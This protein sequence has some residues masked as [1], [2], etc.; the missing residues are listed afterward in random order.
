M[1]VD[2]DYERVPRGPLVEHI[3]EMARE[4][5]EFDDCTAPP[6]P[7]LGGPVDWR[8]ED[9]EDWTVD[10]DGDAVVLSG[11]TEG[12]YQVQTRSATYN[13]PGAAHPAEYERRTVR[14]AVEVR[15]DWS[16][17]PIGEYAIEAFNA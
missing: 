6:E 17:N 8:L 13:P 16:E 1:T 2:Q 9:V 3:L 10:A 15:A 14:V 11:M 7:N 4:G 12:A 5:A